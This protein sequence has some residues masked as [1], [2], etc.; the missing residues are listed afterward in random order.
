MNPSP[1][2][3]SCGMLGKSLNSYLFLDQKTRTVLFIL[4]PARA[5]MRTKEVIYMDTSQTIKDQNG[6]SGFESNDY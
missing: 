3:Y 2:K 5:L 4:L 1:N 6:N